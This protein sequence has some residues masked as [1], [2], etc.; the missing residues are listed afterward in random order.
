MARNVRYV[1]MLRHKDSGGKD[2]SVE[3]SVITKKTGD[4]LIEL[5]QG[6]GVRLAFPPEMA[7]KLCGHIAA[8]A[9]YARTECGEH[10]E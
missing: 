3:V 6:G 10:L 1:K 9:H 5:W 2:R 7:N 4:P 8:A